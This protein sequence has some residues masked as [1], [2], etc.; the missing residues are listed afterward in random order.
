MET[1][2]CEQTGQGS[3]EAG[4]PANGPLG[5]S[6]RTARSRPS[7]LLCRTSQTP[8]AIRATRPEPVSARGV[9]WRV[10]GDS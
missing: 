6:S 3:F 10:T 5:P 7:R 9:G 4:G 8:R 2:G 1:I